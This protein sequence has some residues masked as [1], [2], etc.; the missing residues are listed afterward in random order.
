MKS[1]Q[2]I[3]TVLT[4]VIAIRGNV[5]RNVR[6]LRYDSRSVEKG[7]L[8]VAVNGLD[9]RAL[10]FV[11]DAVAAGAETILLDDPEHMPQ[12]GEGV[13]WVLVRDAR[14][15]MAEVAA[16]LFDYP[17]HDLQLYGITGT[18]GKTTTAHVLKSLLKGSG[19]STGM[20]GTLG[21]TIDSTVPTG[22]TTP[23]SP[24]LM[25]MLAEMR[26]AG[27]KNV[28]MEVSSHAMTLKR[29]DGLRFAGG[30]FTNITQDHLDFHTTFE[31]YLNAKKRFFDRLDRHAHAVVNIDDLHGTT[32]A[33]DSNATIIRYGYRSDAD[34]RISNTTLAPNGSAWVVTLSDLLGGGEINLRTPL[35]GSFNVMNV[36]AACGLAIAAGIDR[37][38]LVDLV[39]QLTPVPGRM[40]T[41]RLHNGVAVVVDYAHT[42]DAL[43]SLLKTTRQFV[44]EGQLIVVFGCGG[45]RD[46]GKRPIMGEIASRLADRIYIT[47]DNPRSEDPDKIID[48]ILEGVS[49]PTTDVHRIADRRKAIELALQ[50]AQADDI[51]VVAGKGH[52]T[53]QIIGSDRHDFDDR[54][55]VRH[56][57]R[58]KENLREQNQHSTR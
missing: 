12:S 49:R 42:P 1:L 2:S 28:V 3:L 9:D 51:V 26:N 25:R 14:K 41:L 6:A 40:E 48:E 35:T 36:T 19:E 15:G 34:L 10:G 5:E 46:R 50:E 58:E 24:E 55:V 57:D 21:M 30:I 13:T 38:R 18:N 52:E 56:W 8:Y 29:V 23:E 20:I 11:P 22:Y 17:M 31:D 53:Y 4:E 43:E 16:F 33:R 45:D 47:S 37:S 7:D 32:M 54:E 39:S 27:V 44:G